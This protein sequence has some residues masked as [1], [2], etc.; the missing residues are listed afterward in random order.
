MGS[1]CYGGENY[2][3]E[4]LRGKAEKS[5]RFCSEAIKELGYFEVNNPA[6]SDSRGRFGFIIRKTAMFEASSPDQR[7]IGEKFVSRIG[8]VTIFPEFAQIMVS[9]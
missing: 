8:I 6:R 1:F 4:A 2:R 5:G 7:P 9:S 3:G